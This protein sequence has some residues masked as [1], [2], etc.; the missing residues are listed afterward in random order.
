MA[1]TTYAELKTSVGDWLNRSDLA[2]VIADF[3]TLA[4]AQIERALRTRQM[5]T[6]LSGTVTA[7]YTALPTDF[8][9]TKTLKLTS[10]NP[11]TALQF[12]SINALD[13]LKQTF[14]SSGKPKFFG[15]AG[16]YFRLL[17]V[18]DTSYTY[19][20]DYYASLANLSGSNTSNWLLA[21]APDVYLYGSLLQ[22]A[23]YLQDD[24]RISVWAALYQRG[25]EDLRVADDRASGAGTMLARARTFG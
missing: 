23:P 1:L 13:D 15:I 17:P 19:E 11:I 8:L 14:T 4:E 25:L 12:E 22:A 16:D 20:L 10:S 5:L 9:E 6:R 24:Q 7:E 18:P 21:M 3:V 2:T